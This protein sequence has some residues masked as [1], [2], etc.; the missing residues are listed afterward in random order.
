MCILYIHMCVYMC[1]SVYILWFSHAHKN[2]FS[3]SIK[4]ACPGGNE[5]SNRAFL[6]LL[7]FGVVRSVTQRRW[8]R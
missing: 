7:T 8:T 5:E 3:P 2:E 1:V 4:N 6:F